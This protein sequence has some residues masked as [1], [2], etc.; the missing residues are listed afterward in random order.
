MDYIN[1]YLIF[2]NL[3][4]AKKY[5]NNGSISHEIVDYLK[6]KFIEEINRPNYM[7]M[8][9]KMVAKERFERGIDIKN[10]ENYIDR[11]INLM[12]KNVK[13]DITNMSYD[14][15]LREIETKE[16]E[17][18]INKV[19]KNYVPNGNIRREIKN[20][21]E[22]YNKLSY[23]VYNNKVDINN[24]G[25]KVFY[26]KTPEDFLNILES[27]GKEHLVKS[28][29][30]DKQHYK[31]IE[32]TEG[33]LFY[34]QKSYDKDLKF[35][36]TYWCTFHMY[37]WNR[38]TE[39]GNLF[40]ILYDKI[41]VDDSVIILYKPKNGSIE[42]YDFY[43]KI[44]YRTDFINGEHKNKELVLNLMERVKSEEI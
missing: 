2:E 18:K 30:N 40:Y 7:G 24:I 13:I 4:Q 20:N 34:H 32:E 3:Q 19:L 42:L 31:V 38:Y 11:F 44:F 33:Y 35:K 39:V 5:V 6:T 25:N 27:D 29:K 41:K 43:D 1:D 8:F 9:A 36:N 23:L 28:I 22:Y 21:K 14:S 37:Y 16:I 12:K 26:I 17:I 10:F 15:F